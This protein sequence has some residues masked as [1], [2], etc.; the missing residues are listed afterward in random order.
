MQISINIY[1]F[2]IN[3]YSL[4]KKILLSGKAVFEFNFTDMIENVIALAEVGRAKD[5]TGFQAEILRIFLAT[6]F[7]ASQPQRIR[8]HRNRTK[9]HG[10]R[11][12]HG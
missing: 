11:R 1:C 6:N 7:R 2:S 5:E 8:N 12:D 10:Q 3:I 4:S 9:A